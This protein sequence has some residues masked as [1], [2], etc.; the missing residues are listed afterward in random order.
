MASVPNDRKS[1]GRPKVGA[2]HVG[3][4]IPPDQL[5][6]LDAFIAAQPEPRP[7]RPKAVR[8]ALIEWLKGQGHLSDARKSQDR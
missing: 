4:R 5:A 8:Q 1:R 7:S 3:V 6:G 2:T